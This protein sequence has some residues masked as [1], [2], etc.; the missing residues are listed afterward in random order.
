MCACSNT[1]IQQS[2]TDDECKCFKYPLGKTDSPDII[3]DFSPSFNRAY[4][5]FKS[6]GSQDG[7]MEYSFVGNI[8]SEEIIF[9]NIENGQLFKKTILPSKNISYGSLQTNEL[10]RLLSNEID[11]LD[12]ITYYIVI[13]CQ[14]IT[15]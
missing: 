13:T 14:P 15:D 9:Y 2:W 12:V 10:F 4:N 3:L 7:I 1:S 11:S 8:G 6:D 5:D